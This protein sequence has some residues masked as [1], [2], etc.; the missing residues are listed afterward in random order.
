MSQL[1]FCCSCCFK[2][3]YSGVQNLISFLVLQSNQWGREDAG[4][5]T[6]IAFHYHVIVSVWCLFLTVLGWSE[7]DDCWL[8]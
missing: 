7:V 3:V 8:L 1:I 5:L 2:G 4:C 6:L